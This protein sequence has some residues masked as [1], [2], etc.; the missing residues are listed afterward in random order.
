MSEE[1]QYSTPARELVSDESPTEEVT[2]SL[3]ETALTYFK[4][5]NGKWQTAVIKYDPITK[6]ATV[7]SLGIENTHKEVV[8]EEF[9]LKNIHMELLT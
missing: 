3:P 2:V 1:V 8:R 7:E 5:A 4:N 6:Q 9:I